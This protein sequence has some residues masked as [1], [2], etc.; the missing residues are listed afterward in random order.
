MRPSKLFLWGLVFG[1]VAVFISFLVRIFL[2]GTYLPEL[3]AQALFSLVPG[4]VESKAVENLGPLAKE[5]AFVGA[6]VVY[7]VLLATLPVIVSRMRRTPKGRTRKAVVFTILPFSVSLALA[8]IFVLLDQVSSNPV[9]TTNTV[10]G[11]LVPSAA[12]G[13]SISSVR[14][15]PR[16]KAPVLFPTEQMKGRFNRKRRLFIKGA[17]GSAAAAVILYYG[18]GLLFPPQQTPQSNSGE[19]ALI[20]ANQVTPNSDFYRVDVNIIAPTVDVSSWS[21]NVH[22]LVN[23]PMA[24]NYDQIQA[25][26]S[27]EEYATLECVS[28]EVGGD[29]MS[30]AKWKG[31]KL[32]DLLSTA[33][34]AAGAD[35]VVF[36]CYDGYDVGIPLENAMG[37]GT[38]LAYEMNGVP[39]PTDHGFPLRAIVPGLYGMMNAK[40]I[41]DIELVSGV[42]QGFWQRMGWE[43]DAHH[44]TGSTIL[45]PGHSQLRDRFD[46]PWSLPNVI[47]N[48]IDV[49]G[50]AFAGDRGINKVEVSSDGGNTWE[51]ASLQ[52]PLSN[53]TWVFWKYE[54]NPT[55]NGAYNLMVR[56]TD[57]TGQVQVATMSDPFPNG[58][59]GYQAVDVTVSNPSP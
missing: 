33:G 48:P 13:V 15:G 44:Q 58:A 28:N 25:L 1:G 27:L 37:D 6:S 23:T 39:L 9:G 34:V 50:V 41:T 38:I 2:G 46:L 18:V 14:L 31:V 7:A 17:V 52:D 5:S 3:A 30:T 45:T 54:W 26:P 29:L 8:G 53:Y 51:V 40:W 11:M 16:P 21:L 4:S 59:T 24:L 55:G 36:K 43:N 57:G 47:G 32:K 22:G 56:A 49:L 19:G 42:Y 35:Y 10:L 20:L 12:F